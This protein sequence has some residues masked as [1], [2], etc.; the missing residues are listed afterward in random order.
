MTLLEEIKAKCDASLIATQDVEAIAV[1]VSKGRVKP[2]GLQIGS[3]TILETI[4]L[5]AGNALL[6]VINSTPGF[7]HVKILVNDGRL[8]ISSPLV[9]ASLD[10]MVKASVLTQEHA[11]ALLALAVMPDP[12]TE[13][14]VRKSLYDIDGTF[15][16]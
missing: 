9:K 12:V 6:D 14:D 10:G 11:D 3:G 15:L 2:S 5:T 8:I 4:G 1:A 7:R 16:G 13:L